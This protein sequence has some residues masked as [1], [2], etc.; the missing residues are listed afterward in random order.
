MPTILRIN[1]Y[2]FFFFSN[3]H[4]PIHIHI[5]KSDKYAKI[6]VKSI[7]VIENYKF[8]SKELK[9]LVKIVKANQEKIVEAWNEYFG[10]R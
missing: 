2:R 3:E 8:T 1:G 6:D 4:E 5:E 10:K 7:E 9:E